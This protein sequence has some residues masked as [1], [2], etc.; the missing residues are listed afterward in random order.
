MAYL[1]IV[2]SFISLIFYLY[3]FKKTEDIICVLPIF[4][5][6]VVLYVIFGVTVFTY[7]TKDPFLLYNQISSEALNNASFMFILSAF[8]FYL[9]GR[10][11][12]NK[13]NKKSIVINNNRLDIK[14]QKSLIFLILS[15]YIM[16]VLGYGVEGLIYR[17]SYIDPSFE[18]NKTI[19]IIFFVSAP[20]ITTLIPFIKRRLTKYTVYLFCFLILFSSSSRFIIM[21]PFLYLIGTFLRYRKI[22][23]YIIAINVSIILV[24]LIFVLQIRYNI[25]HGLIPNTIALITK[26]IDTEFL[27]IGLN[28]ALSFS[29]FGAAYVLSNFSHNNVA[30]IT[31]INPLPSHFLDIQYM[32]D[33]QTMKKTAPMSAISVL[34]LAGYAILI[35][36]Y[37]ITG[38]CFSYIL[39][40]MDGVTFLYYAVVGLF[41]MFTLFSI[42]YNLRGLSRFFYYSLLI[43]IFYI[44]I[45]KF[46]IKKKSS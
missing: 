8:C 26:G 20:F 35:P 36:F 29:L 16:Y 28:Y 18:R 43:F 39:K 37:V 42:Q 5:N 9:G 23:L 33:I 13:K 4:Y 21:L 17:K 15:I 19:L 45:S 7:A 46:K 32:L 2:I 24:G 27:F 44:F 14:Y 3:R 34:A 41:I 10:A 38:A 40:R 22:K 25:H 1:I 31:S 6:F 30:F 12:K 11:I